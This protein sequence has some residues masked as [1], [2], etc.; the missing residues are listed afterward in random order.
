[1][2]PKRSRDRRRSTSLDALTA[3]VDTLAGKAC[4]ANHESCEQAP[5]D[6]RP[7][8]LMGSPPGRCSRCD[9]IRARQLAYDGAHPAPAPPKTV[10]DDMEEEDFDR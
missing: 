2:S 7:L 5:P 3:R 4:I 6:T 9:A 1:M 10:L 8:L